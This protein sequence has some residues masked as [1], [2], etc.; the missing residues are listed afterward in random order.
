ML[1]KRNFTDAFMS[2]RIDKELPPLKRNCIEYVSTD[3]EFSVSDD[4]YSLASCAGRDLYHN[5]DSGDFKPG[6]LLS[7]EAGPELS[8][9]IESL[10]ISET[11]E[12][13]DIY[14]LSNSQYSR[15]HLD[16]KCSRM[17]NK[18]YEVYQKEEIKNTWIRKNKRAICRTCMRKRK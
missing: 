4:D 7:R 6:D 12:I 18:K 13:F 5:Y 9:L 10:N 11:A 15:F 1:F 3:E 14:V 8:V 2:I 17:K 16:E